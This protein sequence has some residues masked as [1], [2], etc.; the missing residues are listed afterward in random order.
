MFQ[1]LLYRYPEMS[2]VRESKI[3]HKILIDI[4]A[5]F[6]RYRVGF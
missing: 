1:H 6:G 5:L 3:H 4:Q 2:R